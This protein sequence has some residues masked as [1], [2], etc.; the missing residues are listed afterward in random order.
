MVLMR[1][2]VIRLVL[3]TFFL[4]VV[5]LVMFFIVW[6]LPFKEL[7][8]EFHLFLMR[9]LRFFIH[10]VLDHYSLLFLTFI[11]LISFVVLFYRIFYMAGDVRLVRFT[12]I[13]VFFVGSMVFMV[14][15]PS[16][17]GFIFG[18]DGLGVTSFLLVV[19]YA[20]ISSLR[21]GLVTIYI[22]RLGDI[23]LVISLFL[24][25][26][27]GWMIIDFFFLHD[28][29][30]FSLVILVAGITK[31]AQ[32]P[33]SSWLPAA[34]SAPT[35]VSSL[36]HSST[37]VTAGVY[38]FIRFFF[39][40]NI[41]LLAFFFTLLS[42][43]TCFSAGIIA[44]MERDLKKLVAMSTLS[45]IG[46][47]MFFMSIGHVG[48]TFFHIVCHALFKS[49]I[50]LTCGIY[51]LLSLGGQDM[52]FLGN[53]FS[54]RKSF[55]FVLIVSLLRL[56]GFPFLAGFFSK[57]L[58]VDY[59]FNQEASILVLFLFLSACVLSIL[60]RYFVLKLR[61]VSHYLGIRGV[62]V[63][64]SGFIVYFLF[65]LYFWSI[66]LG[67]SLVYFIL[68]GEF[69]M[70]FFAQKLIG[71]LF[72]L[73]FV[74]LLTS[75]VLIKWGFSMFNF[76]LEMLNINWFFAGWATKKIENFYYAVVGDLFWLEVFG[77]Q[78]IWVLLAKSQ[79]F[80]V[81]NNSFFKISLI[82]FIS[83][84]FFLWVLLF[85]LYKALFWRFKEIR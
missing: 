44:C 57:D 74:F 1:F 17:L 23:F 7:V 30:F 55:Y 2:K 56:C 51:I 41:S 71:V 52:R 72:F 60:Y 83:F 42:L 62:N 27:Y 70:I 25:M 84:L 63:F 69:Y 64:F 67:K 9:D 36:V 28:F 50:F 14:L 75:M 22:N 16:L 18:W 61:L 58:L 12:V 40:F 31:R 46:F 68:D 82:F 39:I 11:V 10:F 66:C 49:L 33:F 73:L 38:I 13:V 37:L 85:S 8:L 43:L 19:Y 29:I 77:A 53:K 32:I 78:G 21:S 3:F 5:H 26:G 4:L 48:L 65:L 24:L 80:L 47:L 54:V 34:I 35:P 79:S 20:N 6:T 81:A 45:Q 59:F 76:F 15:S